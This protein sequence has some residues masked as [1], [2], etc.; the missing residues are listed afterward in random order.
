[1]VILGSWVGTTLGPLILDSLRYEITLHA[2]SE[3]CA[4]VHVVVSE[5]GTRAPSLGAATVAL[6]QM[7]NSP[8][9]ASTRAVR[10]TKEQRARVGM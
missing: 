9:A 1:M 10:R 7:L 5:L 3:L 8:E 6:E 4:A 2:M